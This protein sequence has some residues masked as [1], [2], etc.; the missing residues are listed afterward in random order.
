MYWT[1]KNPRA[2]LLSFCMLSTVLTFHCSNR[3][4]AQ[5]DVPKESPAVRLLK[6]G[7][8]PAERL[9]TVIAIIGRQGTSRDLSVLLEKAVDPKAFPREVRIK[10]LDTLADTA[11]NR[12]LK[13]DA[14]LDLILQLLPEPGQKGDS[15]VLR[16]AL[17]NITA[18]KLESASPKLESIARSGASSAELREIALNG[19]A[20]LGGEKNVAILTAL[21]SQEQPLDVRVIALASLASVEPDKAAPIT[22]E[23]LSSKQLPTNR[24]LAQVLNGFLIKANGPSALAKAVD[25]AKIS[26]D[27]AK[28]AL[29][30]LYAIGRSDAE[31]VTALSAAAGIAS[32]VKPLSDEELKAMMV[33]V[34]DKGDARRGEEIFR[35]EENSC[36]KCHAISG[37]GGQ[38]GPELSDVG[39]VS[40]V[41]YLINSVMIPELAV[42]ELYQMMTVLT[43]D[44]RIVQGIIVDQDEQRVKLKDADG[45][46]FSLTTSEI[47][48][49]KMGGSLMPKG[50]PNLMTRQ[51]FLDLVRFLSELG[52]PGD[53]ARKTTKTIQRW[54][55]LNH[56]PE[57]LSA[58]APDNQ[59][60]QTILNA[61]GSAWTSAYAKFHGD[62]PLTAIL[63]KFP[64]KPEVLYLQGE[65]DVTG[66]GQ[67][68]LSLNDVKGVTAWINDQPIALTLLKSSAESATKKASADR[69]QSQA[70]RQPGQF[71]IP[72]G[73]QKVTLRIDLS[74]FS[75]DSL[76]A[77]FLPVEFG[78]AILTVVGGK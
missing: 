37:A 66:R 71:L 43:T 67:T 45:T 22:V 48:E 31:L 11:A 32:E 58:P 29:R 63:E 2:L 35:R 39:G 21:T 52:K 50:L 20:Q 38:V 25:S 53:Y 5:D 36:M 68:R 62:L 1:G 60:I 64:N 4:E 54:H 12:N 70:K 7:K 77:E 13:P 49:K 10:A 75:A 8:V 47:E 23:L 74:K 46:E 73:R 44:G 57:E 14:N 72:I 6:S 27:T 76:R 17:R 41:D 19:L 40:P 30:Q 26:Q 59:V 33:E 24:Q 78:Q 56:P 69:I 28:L 61:T 15:G 9:G 55:V 18:W 34:A 51:E 65:L 3:I 16:A 42:K